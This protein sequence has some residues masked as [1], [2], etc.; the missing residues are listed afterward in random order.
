M[1]YERTSRHHAH[2]IVIPDDTEWLALSMEHTH[3]R[4]ASYWNVATTRADT[5]SKGDTTPWSELEGTAAIVAKANSLLSPS[6]F[7]AAQ[8][9]QVRL[10]T[11]LDRFGL[12]A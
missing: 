10:S 7:L 2:L 9:C 8:K 11:K 12:A 3:G 1:C 5:P 4:Y 6:R